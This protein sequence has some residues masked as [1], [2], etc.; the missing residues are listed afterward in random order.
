MTARVAAP[1]PRDF[2]V[3]WLA[4]GVSQVGDGV[5]LLALPWAA[6]ALTGSARAAAAVVAIRLL[7]YPLSAVFVGVL[8]DAAD[9][10]RVLIATDLARAAL[11]ALLGLLVAVQAMSLAL[12][13]ATALLVGVLSAAFDACYNAATPRLV[14]AERLSRAN[15]LLEATTAAAYVVGP[16]LA[17]LALAAGG[18]AVVF[19]ANACSF[20][21]GAAGSALIRTPLGGDAPRRPAPLRMARDGARYLLGSPALLGLSAATFVLAL[22]LGAVDASL[23]PLLRGQAGFDE[24]EVALVFSGGAAGWLLASLL[25]ARS[26]RPRWSSRLVAGALGASGG[27]ALLSV[28]PT[29]PLAALGLL[30]F[31]AGSISFLITAITYRQRVVPNH[32]LGRVHAL[33]RTIGLLGQPVGAALAGALVSEVTASV[34]IRLA[35]VSSLGAIAVMGPRRLHQPTDGGA[36][37]RT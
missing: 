17:G 13:V 23:V 25:L 34:V 10:R 6:F 36:H 11:L 26:Y 22:G 33:A 24:F 5:M 30:A 9:R 31:Q 32:L 21:V 37:A 19:L 12:L 7:P 8:A 1:L 20:C 15:G 3:L 18:L 27:A 4:Q 14:D 2:R 35:A 29:A 28:A 16:Q